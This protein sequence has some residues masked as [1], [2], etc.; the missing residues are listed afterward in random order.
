MF[1]FFPDHYAKKKVHVLFQA[2]MM[3]ISINRIK[4]K[5]FGCFA[6]RADRTRTGC[7]GMTKRM[8]MSI[9]LLDY[10]KRL[11]IWPERTEGQEKN[12]LLVTWNKDWQILPGLISSFRAG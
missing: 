10:M 8:D 5:C 3:I 1:N 7:L 4:G 9:I 6:F 2:P 12:S 11:A